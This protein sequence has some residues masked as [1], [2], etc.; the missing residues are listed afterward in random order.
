MVAPTAFWAS[1]AKVQTLADG[2]I[3]VTLDLPETAITQMAEL[4]AYKVHGV[5]LD[6]AC[7]AKQEDERDSPRESRKL[8]I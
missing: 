8:H 7:V 3:R 1:V 4:V 2:G 5:V 6:V